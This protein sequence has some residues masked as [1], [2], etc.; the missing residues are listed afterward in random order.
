VKLTNKYLRQGLSFLHV[1]R[2]PDMWIM[3]L[4]RKALTKTLKWVLTGFKTKLRLTLPKQLKES[5]G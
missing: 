4:L 1:Y 2:Y 5:D 3:R